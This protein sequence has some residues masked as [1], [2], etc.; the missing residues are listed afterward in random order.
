MWNFNTCL[1]TSWDT[2]I[3]LGTT[4]CSQDLGYNDDSCGL[5]SEIIVY[6]EPGHYF[7]DIEGYSTCGNY[8]FDVR[9]EEIC[10]VICPEG[11]IPEAEACGDDTNGGC[12]MT[13]PQF[14]PIACNT[15]ICGTGWF[16]GS[17]RD[18]DWYEYIPANDDTMTFAC[19]A[20]FDVLFG[21][22]E[23]IVPGVPGCDNVTGYL[24][25]YQLLPDCTPASVT[26][27]VTAGGTYYVFVAPQFTG[28]FGCDMPTIDYVA[29]L[30]G[31]NCMCGDFDNDGDVDTDDF[32]FFLDAFGSCEGDE[33]YEEACDFDGDACIT[34]VDYQMWMQCYRDANG[35]SFVAPL[36]QTNARPGG[37]KA[38][39]GAIRR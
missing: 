20:E 34:L 12:N 10:E 13:V 33:K 1:D 2:Y 36:H 26:F 32:Y 25:P 19:E 5:Q 38:P 14:E 21:L 17:T 6:I 39:Q 8:I 35:K 7:C 37:Q 18:T 3:F 30:T 28:V 11:A 23:Q 16:D 31:E 9:L 27:P 15:T 24:N 4:L 29:T 22:L